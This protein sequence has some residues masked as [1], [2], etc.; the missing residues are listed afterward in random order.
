MRGRGS[1]RVFAGRRG[2]TACWRRA[3]I[4]TVA[5]AVPLTIVAGAAGA[6][7]AALVGSGY[8]VTATSAGNQSG[9]TS[10]TFTLKVRS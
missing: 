8:A 5:A 4:A 9:T 6:A 10:E 7:G 3:V 2:R 1:H